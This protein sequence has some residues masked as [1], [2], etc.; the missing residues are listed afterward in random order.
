MKEQRSLFWPLTFIATGVIWLMIS[1]GRIPTENLWALLYIWPY[2]LIALG[3]GLILRSVWRPL[4]A[5]V[6][7]LVVVG[8]SLA[9]VF[10]PQLGWN[11]GPSWAMDWQFQ[12]G[13]TGSVPGSGK[14]EE[15]TRKVS[16]FNAIDIRYPAE[17]VIKQ[18]E[19]E[20]LTIEA[21]DNL[22]SQITTEVRSGTLVIE[23]GED[24]F[25]KRVDPTRPVKLTITV[26]DLEEI[27]FSSAGQLTVESLKGDT[28][29]VYL[30]G[31]G[32]I[33]LNDLDLNRLEARLSGAGAITA[34]GKADS[35]N[36]S[37]SGVGDFDGS[38]LATLTADVR[39]SGLGSISIRV[40]DELVATVSGAGSV[41]YYGS[42]KV[43][44]TISGAGDVSQG[45]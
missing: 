42:P 23:N 35:A 27:N 5:L 9:V 25:S 39:I 2:L 44:K 12:D 40:E 22:L 13:V 7:I 28:L 4:G 41:T 17:V 3:L 33:T 43:T 8:A 26:T 29:K 34:N 31:A 45:D 36:I 32:D 38:E 6:T 21:E 10:A 15:E 16:D 18:G 11:D 1:L 24:N 30:S 14:I 20:S 37:I 19:S